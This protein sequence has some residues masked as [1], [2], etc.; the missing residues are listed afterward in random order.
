[1]PTVQCPGR[2]NSSKPR[3][4]SEIVKPLKRVVSGM[5]SVLLRKIRKSVEEL[6]KGMLG[7][8]KYFSSIGLFLNVHVA[9]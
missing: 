1:M 7:Y 5:G 9:Y 8:G 4:V 2:P 3:S 6:G